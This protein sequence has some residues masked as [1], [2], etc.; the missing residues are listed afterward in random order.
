MERET[1]EI[2]SQK[3]TKLFERLRLYNRTPVPKGRW[4]TR[5]GGGGGGESE[6]ERAKKKRGREERVGGA[7][8][9]IVIEKLALSAMPTPAY[10]SIRQHTSAYAV[11]EQSALS[12][13]PTLAETIRLLAAYIYT[14]NHAY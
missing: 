1:E 10:V 8:G 4:R 11:T 7:D 5:G 6:S 2:S 13:M 9:P 3:K 14:S 12:A